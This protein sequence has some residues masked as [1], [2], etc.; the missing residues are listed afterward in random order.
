MRYPETLKELNALVASVSGKI[1]KDQL[2]TIQKLGNM[3][4]HNCV[5]AA[6]RC[7]A[8]KSDRSLQAI[9][10]RASAAVLL[11]AFEVF[12]KGQ[13]TND[14]ESKEFLDTIKQAALTAVSKFTGVSVTY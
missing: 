14:A 2:V 8:V 4:G 11:A 7:K 6:I 9:H 12:A 13:V 10:S 3:I 5:V 1:S